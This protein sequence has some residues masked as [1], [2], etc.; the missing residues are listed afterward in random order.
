VIEK[1]FRSEVLIRCVDAA[2]RGNALRI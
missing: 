2:L 1:P